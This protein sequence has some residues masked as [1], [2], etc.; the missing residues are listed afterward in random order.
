[1]SARP[2]ARLVRA[3]IV[4]MRPYLLFV[5]GITGL[6]GLALGP[7]T[8][9][10]R[11][12]LAG[13][14]FF[15]SYGFGQ[16]LTDCFQMDTDALSAP[17]RPLVR[18]RLAR[19]PVLG[20]SLGGLLL[21]GLILV[22]YHPAN[23]A[24]A[25]LAVGGLATYTWFKR[26]W[27]GGPFYN[28]WIVALLVVMGY[29]VAAGWHAT[30]RVSDGLGGLLLLAFFGYANFVLTG[31]YK[32]IP[33]DRATGYRTLPVVFGLGVSA[34]VSDAF[35]VAA[36]CGAALAARPA[37]VAGPISPS[38]VI[39]PLLLSAGV[40]TTVVGQVRLHRV[41]SAATAYRAIVPVVHAYVLL[42]AGVTSL[43]R[44]GWSASL[45]VFYAAF[46]LALARRPEREQI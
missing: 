6:A 34:L 19:G 37:V 1:M 22:S 32:D 33:A 24:L 11:T 15:L 42:L 27:W 12:W 31:Y 35:A 2:V 30:D 38:Y 23:G 8:G 36:L 43:H 13:G 14:A 17:Y 46:A 3:Y 4:T 44:P 26:R 10:G 25:L 41:R 40:V 28:A 20:T 16:A 39:G 18:G 45:L 7:A 5:S 29:V 9:A 21:C